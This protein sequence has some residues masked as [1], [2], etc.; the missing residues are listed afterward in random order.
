MSQTNKRMKKAIADKANAEARLLQVGQE[1]KA[2]GK[3]RRDCKETLR[4]A[5]RRI[6]EIATEKE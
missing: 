1:W 4:Q 5:I 6:E 2:L 3:L